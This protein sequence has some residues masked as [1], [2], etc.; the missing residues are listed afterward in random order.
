MNATVVI[1]GMHRS[2]TS[3]LTHALALLGA[4]L[5]PVAN[6]GR[7]W[8]TPVMRRPNDA[9]LNAFGGGWDCPPQMPDGWV[10]SEAVQA[11]LPSAR[12]AF[13]EYGSPDILVWK[14]PRTCMTLP[15]WRQLFPERPV[16]VFVHRHPV[17]V[18]DSLT[19]RNGFHLAHGL[20]LWERYNHAALQ[21]ATGLPTVAIPYWRLVEKPKATMRVIV[22]ALA[23]WG[24]RLPNPPEWT[25][26]ELTPQ[27]RH[28]LS[29]A[30]IFDAPIATE[31]QR[32][33][34]RLIQTLPTVSDSFAPPPLPES[35]PL[36]D[37]IID[38][39][40]QLRFAR[41]EARRTREEL[42]KLKG[43]RRR[44]LRQIVQTATQRTKS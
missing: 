18:A 41:I 40:A 34:F 33:L 32:D 19:A 5:G 35:N 30:D 11:I 13:A 2:G 24:V 8:E 7:N 1:L 29:D 3:A 38:S 21:N 27:R 9:L 25:D 15:F 36:T 22:D 12:A 23:G 10:E 17:E 16:I 6:L 26:M 42:R 44:L 31:P 4:S 28:H 20:A 37:E 39:A 43:S 14:D